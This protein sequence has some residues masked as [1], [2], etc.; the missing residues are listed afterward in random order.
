LVRVSVSESYAEFSETERKDGRLIGTYP[1]SPPLVRVRPTVSLVIDLPVGVSDQAA[2]AIE[3]ALQAMVPTEVMCDRRDFV[4]L[5]EPGGTVYLYDRNVDGLGFAERAFERL[6]AIAAAAA[7]RVARC[8]CVFG[9]PLCIQSATCERWNHELEK[10]EASRV[11]DSVL[12]LRRE[13]R[14]TTGKPAPTRSSSVR[15]VAHSVADALIDEQ[16][17]SSV[18]AM[19]S[20]I[21]ADNE[22]TTDEGWGVAEFRQGT[23]VRHAAFGRGTVLGAVDGRHGPEVTVRFDDQQRR[24]IVGGVGNFLVRPASGSSSG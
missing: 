19:S 12:G 23:V 21:D 3:H 7:E 14:T 10:D 9:C 16:R 13:R 11:L 1:I 8:G 18:A 20:R 4:G 24:R 2:H 22:W 17:A 15:D 5:S 6:P